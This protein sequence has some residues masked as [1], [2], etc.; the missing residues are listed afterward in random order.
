MAGLPLALPRLLQVL[1]GLLDLR[2]A[3]MRQT[4]H[5]SMRDLHLAERHLRKL[6]KRSQAILLPLAATGRPRKLERLV[7]QCPRSSGYD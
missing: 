2:L 3:I 5:I 6:P 7:L 4:Y 1:L